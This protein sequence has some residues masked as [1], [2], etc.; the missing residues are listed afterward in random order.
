MAID[1]IKR[2]DTRR[3]SL[4]VNSIFAPGKQRT[5]NGAANSDGFLYRYER[6][7]WL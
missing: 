6:L 2:T 4:Q 7:Y 5:S 3:V 1:A